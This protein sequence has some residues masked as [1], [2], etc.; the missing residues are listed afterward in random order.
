M[1]YWKDRKVLVTGATGLMGS[2]LTA[3]LLK[4]G[5]LV[6]AIVRDSAPASELNLSGNIKKIS[7]VNGDIT[8]YQVM[9]RAFNEY[10][11]QNCFHLAAQTIVGTA[12]RSPISTFEANIKGTW[13]VLE[14]AR[15]SKLNPHIVVASSDKAYGDQEKLPYTEDMPLKGTYPYDASKSC[16]DIIS[17]SYAKTYGMPVAVSRFANLFGG[18]DLNFSRLIPGTMLWLLKNEPIIIR[19][20]GNFRRDFL[21]VEDAAE[22][23]LTLAE[24]MEKRD[25]NG[26]AFNFGNGEPIKVIDLVKKIIK[27]TGKNVPIKIEN[28]AK[29]EI[30]DQ[31]LSSEKSSRILG[32]QPSHSLDSGLKK[33]YEWYE[34]HY[35]QGLF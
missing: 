30:K 14:A 22:A 35:K 2:W 3:K 26:E 17:F 9:L 13:T 18:G 20:D 34:K 16:T 32:W 8:D 19:S 11:I 28:T 24:Q 10:E 4:E 6:T 5:A 31:Y 1:G 29:H 15:N 23:Y 25:V 33:T 12:S 7:T 21:Y 27:V